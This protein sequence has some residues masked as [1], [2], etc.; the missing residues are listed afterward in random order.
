MAKHL[1]RDLDAIKI[2][3]LSIG[4]LVEAAIRDSVHSLTARRV[5]LAESVIAGDREIDLREV[6]LEDDCLK[7][8][9]LHQPVAADL[10]FVVAVLKVNNDLERMGD[11][12]VNI[13]KRAIV[14]AA[15]DSLSAQLDLTDMG[16]ATI[17]MVKHSLESLVRTDV[18]A[19]RAVMDADEVVDAHHLES[20]AAAKEIIARDSGAAERAIELLSVSRNLERIGDLATNIAEDV[21]S[22]VEGE[23][24]RHRA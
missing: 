23:I 13:A 6:S 16:E 15:E 2:E 21:V 12:A 14:L 17:G 22:L 5:E 11:L 7:V 18:E 1:T 19:A 20:Y 9:A 4:S 24:I 3:T 8:L 10:R